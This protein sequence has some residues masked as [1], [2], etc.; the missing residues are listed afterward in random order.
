M[1]RTALYLIIVLV[2]GVGL[3]LYPTLLSGM[4][5]ST[6]AWP[7][8]KNTQVLMQHT[9][10]P[11]N[12][13]VFDGYNNF[14]P[15]VT[16]Y[17]AIAAQI[18]ALPAAATMAYAVPLAAAFTLPLF[19]LLAKKITDSHTVA[20]L[21]TALL[22]TAYPY[23]LFTAGV[24]KETFASPLY[25]FVLLLFL[26]KHNWKTTLLFTLASVALVLAH[27]LTAFL[28]ATALICLTVA[29]YLSRPKTPQPNRPASNLMYVGVLSGVALTDFAVFASSAHMPTLSMNDLLSIAAYQV[30][31]IAVFAYAA[32]VTKC[33]SAK[34]VAL[35][36]TLAFA[37]SLAFAY[38]LT[39]VP[40]LPGA[41]MLP[42]RYLLYALP[43][44]WAVALAIFGLNELYQRSS[45]LLLPLFWLASILAVAGYAVFAGSLNGLGL[46]YRLVDFVLP[47]LAILG[48][49]GFH[50]LVRAP[51]HRLRRSV[52][53]VAVTAV[54]V[55]MVALSVYTLFAAVSL[56]EPY[57]GYFWRYH[58]SEY[59]AAS[60]AANRGS[61]SM[62]GDA[63]VCYLLGEYYGAKVSVMGGYQFLD[64][65]GSPPQTFYVYSGMYTNGY[66]LYQGSAVPL[67]R[68]WTEKLGG[69]NQV[70][71][72]SEVTI[73]AKP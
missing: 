17:G 2:V 67:P 1:N 58:P 5:F 53:L 6:D 22:A 65:D 69:Y 32:F 25:I 55:L 52:T 70:Y 45:A 15:V 20:L 57:L 48:A 3:R 72:N 51:K 8:I 39:A 16:L 41:P 19:Y 50:R 63:K 4:P 40:L 29:L 49:I 37:A 42:L 71:F 21:A 12:S 7:L 27:H 60:W 43:L 33:F 62:A 61:G 35:N 11:L 24:T 23:T 66:V 18:T 59:S 56:Q 46:A 10:V 54:A 47:P 73:Y 31:F 26:Q 44:I 30:F 34:V 14:W 36:C 64:G 9:P 68:N 28:T 38:M 13:G